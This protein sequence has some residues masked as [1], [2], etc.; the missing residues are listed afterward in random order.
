MSLVEVYGFWQDKRSEEAVAFFPG[1]LKANARDFPGSG[2][3]LVVIVAVDLLF[4]HRADFF[5][6]CQLLYSAGSDNAVL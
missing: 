4:Q 5:D 2:M 1:F 6:S 3:D